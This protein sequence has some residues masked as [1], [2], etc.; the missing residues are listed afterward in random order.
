MTTSDGRAKSPE[1]LLSGAVIY[2]HSQTKTNNM[3]Q[4]VG[5][6]PVVYFGSMDIKGSWTRT[7]NS[8]SVPSFF[9]FTLTMLPRL[10]LLPKTME[11]LE[12]LSAL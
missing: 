4:Y 5:A 7:E 2:I 9:V 1:P 10:F 8:F 12:K 3:R 11:D 6:R